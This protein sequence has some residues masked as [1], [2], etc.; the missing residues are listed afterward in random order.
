MV[1]V[2]APAEARSTILFSNSDYN[3]SLVCYTKDTSGGSTTKVTSGHD[4]K[5]S[6]KGYVKCNATWRVRTFGR[7]PGPWLK[8]NKW[9]AIG[10]QQIPLSWIVAQ[11]K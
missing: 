4:D 3:R 7:A 8:S 1:A 5:V 2:P 9:Y 10:G 11:Q 6:T